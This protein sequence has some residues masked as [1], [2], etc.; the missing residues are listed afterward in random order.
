M[1]IVALKTANN[2]VLPA[3]GARSVVSIQAIGLTA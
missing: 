2:W 3:V 1:F